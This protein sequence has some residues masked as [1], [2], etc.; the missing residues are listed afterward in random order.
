MNADLKKTASTN[1]KKT[2]GD[3]VADLTYAA[4]IIRDA[5]ELYEKG[6]LYQLGAISSQLR[7]LLADKEPLLKSVADFDK[8]SLHVY[9]GAI[10]ST[11]S[12]LKEHELHLP[13][14]STQPTHS[15]D[16]RLT[17]DEFLAS[18]IN[19]RSDERDTNWT[20][21][22]LYADK[23][24]GA[25]SDPSTPS[26][27]VHLRKIGDRALDN[28]I[29]SLG[30]LAL[31]LCSIVLRKHLDFTVHFS[32]T[33]LEA[34]GSSAILEIG[35]DQSMSRLSVFLKST[36]R[37]DFEI[38]G[39]DGSLHKFVLLEQTELF[40]SPIICTITGK[41]EKDGLFSILGWVN[42]RQTI[43][44]KLPSFPLFFN[45]LD[46]LPT[47]LHHSEA[48]TTGESIFIFLKLLTVSRALSNN[49][50]NALYLQSLSHFSS[51]PAV[52]IYFFKET[53]GYSY[54]P[55]INGIEGNALK[56]DPVGKT[57]DASQYLVRR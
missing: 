25:H 33:L 37:L 24:G 35:E 56:L 42:G 40:S 48:P 32:I 7:I 46:E 22:R 57:V 5:V 2:D 11:T 4:S 17:L 39:L 12:D 36:N 9:V 47:K 3:R 31:D 23:L 18:R 20:L 14:L 38:C 49:E 29:V 34:S 16:K 8:T 43:N 28:Y 27:I 45:K 53:K 52:G 19:Q 21:I 10:T 50:R 6:R 1:I 51:S 54:K 26:H 44:S 55:I 13:T 15:S 41:V 30:R